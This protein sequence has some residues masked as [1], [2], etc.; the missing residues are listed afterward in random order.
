[1]MAVR[2]TNVKYRKEKM[3]KTLSESFNDIRN[4]IT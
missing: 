2:T 4:N 1:M 3:A